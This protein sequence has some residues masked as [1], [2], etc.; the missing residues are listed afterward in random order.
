MVKPNI[1]TRNT[2]IKITLLLVICTAIY[3]SENSSAEN[4]ITQSKPFCHCPEVVINKSASTGGA[5][6]N[7]TSQIGSG[8]CRCPL[9]KLHR[10]GKSPIHTLS[11]KN[12]HN[13]KVLQ[14]DHKVKLARKIRYK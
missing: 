11:E 7:K 8:L 9:K 2:F 12:T 10:Y 14:E 1:S 13:Q 4:L 5:K 6:E 3:A